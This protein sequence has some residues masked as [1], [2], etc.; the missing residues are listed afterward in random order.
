MIVFKGQANASFYPIPGHRAVG[1]IDCYLFGAADKGDMLLAGKGASIENNWY[2]HSKI[3]FLG[4]TIENHRVM[5]HTRGSKKKKM[6]EEELRSMVHGKRLTT[7][8]GCGKALMP[9]A[10]FN[11]CFLIYHALHHFISEGLRM[12]QILDWALFLQKEQA[13]VDWQAFNSFC[14]RYKL[15][16]FAA[17]MNYIACNHLGIALISDGITNDRKYA[18]KILQS[19]FY[20]NGYLFNSGR[21]GWTIRWL[22]VKNMLTCDRW[23]YED[24]AQESVWKHLWQSVSGYLFEKD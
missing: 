3:S 16:R 10:Q 14:Q 15:D 9:T 4:E 13:H 2:R 12:K 8:E 5:S 24:I 1:D 6:M 22:L 21:S 17:A 20:D 7:I 19:T 18:D 11:A 23:K